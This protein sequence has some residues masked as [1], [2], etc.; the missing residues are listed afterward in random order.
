MVKVANRDRDLLRS[1]WF[2]DGDL[3]DEPKHYRSTVY[4]FGAKSSP[5]CANFALHQ[6]VLEPATRTF[7]NAKNVIQNPFYVDDLLIF[8]NDLEA[9]IA[10]VTEVRSLLERRG[11][12]LTS[13]VSTSDELLSV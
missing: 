2:P 12:N 11:F 6:T 9:D 4:V 10:V 5:T 3:F 1:H 13:F 8:F 7:V